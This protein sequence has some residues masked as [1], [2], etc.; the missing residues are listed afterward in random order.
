MREGEV[1]LVH[2]FAARPF[3]LYSMYSLNHLAS[4]YSQK[5]FMPTGMSLSARVP[6]GTQSHSPMRNFRASA[7]DSLQ[8]LLG[9]PSPS[10]DVA[11]TIDGNDVT[12]YVP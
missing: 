4:D 8:L 5:H 7:L 2:E 11:A 9:L 6:I 1:R 12:S 10:A 3:D